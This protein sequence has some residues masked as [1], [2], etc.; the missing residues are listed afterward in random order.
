MQPMSWTQ[1]AHNQDK[2]QQVPELPSPQ[3]QYWP[4]SPA[5]SE[6]ASCHPT[7]APPPEPQ[8]TTDSS[9]LPSNRGRWSRSPGSER[10]CLHSPP[11]ESDPS[12]PN[13]E[14]RSCRN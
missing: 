13:A 2:E 6:S 9:V 10:C 1:P 12:S 14:Y 11:S 7:L 5:H 3:S 4:L 8:G